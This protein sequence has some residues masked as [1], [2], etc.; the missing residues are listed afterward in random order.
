MRN[1]LNVFLGIE[2][3]IKRIVGLGTKST[4]VYPHSFLKI[5]EKSIDNTFS[6]PVMKKALYGLP[7][8]TMI[9]EDP[10]TTFR[11][12]ALGYN[13][14]DHCAGVG[15]ANVRLVCGQDEKMEQKI[16]FT[17]HIDFFTSLGFTLY[18]IEM[19]KY[20]KKKY[21]VE[22][23]SLT[24]K[25]SRLCWKC[26]EQK[27]DLKKCS[28]CLVAQYCNKDC[29]TQDWNVHKKLHDLEKEFKRRR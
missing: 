26:F 13:D 27:A 16:A 3:A 17:C 6:T 18:D 23:E 24:K 2:V 25:W 21:G 20:I 5:G 12:F 9:D 7:I 11:R 4:G 28:K 1:C 22:L 19:R 10:G 29:Q 15:K 8:Q 14:L